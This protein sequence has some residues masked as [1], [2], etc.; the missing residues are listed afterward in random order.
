MYDLVTAGITK[1]REV[2]AAPESPLESR[3]L[4]RLAAG[5]RRRLDSIF[6]DILSR[7]LALCTS[8][9]WGEQP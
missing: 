1:S 2:A 7:R 5:V 3:R 9:K 6:D 4:A 8:A